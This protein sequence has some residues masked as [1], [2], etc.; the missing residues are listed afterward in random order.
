MACPENPNVR[1]KEK[2]SL[3]PSSKV[4]IFQTLLTSVD[5]TFQELQNGLVNISISGHIMM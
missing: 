4:R 5:R 2:R 1:E 3:N